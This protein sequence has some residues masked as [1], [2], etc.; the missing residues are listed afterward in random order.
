MQMAM[1]RGMASGGKE[2]IVRHI[3]DPKLKYLLTYTIKTTKSANLVA[4]SAGEYVFLFFDFDNLVVGFLF[5][6]GY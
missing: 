2:C 1:Q 4:L 3:A 5:K 6:R